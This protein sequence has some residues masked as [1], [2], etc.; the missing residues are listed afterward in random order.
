MVWLPAPSD[1]VLKVAFPALFRVPVP[2]VVAGVVIP[3]K[4]VTVPVGAPA[5]GAATV[6]VAVSVT[7]WPKVAGLGDAAKLV[8][9]PACVTVCM[10]GSAGG[11]AEVLAA[12]FGSPP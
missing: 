3:S 9:V 7:A 1:E 2:H 8:F 10:R 6:I 5:P 12:K 11:G 4:N